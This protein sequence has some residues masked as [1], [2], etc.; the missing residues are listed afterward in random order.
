[1]LP[2]LISLAFIKH[3]ISYNNFT[4]LTIQYPHFT[5]EGKKAK[6]SSPTCPNLADNIKG[7]TVFQEICLL[8]ERSARG[9]GYARREPG[10]EGQISQMY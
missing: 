10:T 1:M 6:R 7:D 9:A 5:E 4:M 8:S 3:L 2:M